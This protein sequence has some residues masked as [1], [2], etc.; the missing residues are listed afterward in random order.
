MV[1][2]VRKQAHRIRAGVEHVLAVASAVG[3]ASPEFVRFEK[4]KRKPGRRTARKL[5]CDGAAAKAAPDDDDVYVDHARA[6]V[7]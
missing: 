4:G 6:A 3:G 7:A 2:I 1:G 5:S